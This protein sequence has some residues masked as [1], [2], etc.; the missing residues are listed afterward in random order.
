MPRQSIFVNDGELFV[1]FQLV[2]VRASTRV[3][4]GYRGQD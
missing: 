4:V 1:I 3:Y 2:F